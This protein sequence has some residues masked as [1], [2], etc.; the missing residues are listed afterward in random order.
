[1][2]WFFDLAGFHLEESLGTIVLL[3]FFVL[4][5]FIVGYVMT[6]RKSHYDSVSHLPLDNDQQSNKE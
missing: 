3:G 5:V 4:F 2:K 6:R 1:M